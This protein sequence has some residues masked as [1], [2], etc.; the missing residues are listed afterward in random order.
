M[1]GKKE[2]SRK[3][4]K[5]YIFATYKLTRPVDSK[6]NYFQGWPSVYILVIKV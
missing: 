1:L 4:E 2:K 5:L 6:Q 3:R